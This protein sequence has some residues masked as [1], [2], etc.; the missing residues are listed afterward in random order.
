MDETQAHTYLLTLPG[1]TRDYPFGPDVAV[2]RVM[3]KMFATLAQ[4]RGEPWF[5]L[6][7]KCDPF[8]AQALRDIFASVRPGYHMNKSL[9]NTLV[10]DDSIPRGEIERMME[11]SYALIVA[12]LAKKTRLALLDA[13]PAASRYSSSI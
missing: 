8:E 1:A 12:S 10:L 9:W 7:L 6:N 11:N 4:G 5:W 2:Y 3:N 13:Y